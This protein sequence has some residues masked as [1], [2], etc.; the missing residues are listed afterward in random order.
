M[1]KKRLGQFLLGGVFT[2]CAVVIA[3]LADLLAKEEQ[4][5]A[6]ENQTP[7]KNR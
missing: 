1:N 7:E 2:A 6:P 4:K 3:A 5:P